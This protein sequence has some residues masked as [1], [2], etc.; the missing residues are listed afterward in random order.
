M[1]TLYTCSNNNGVA[2]YALDG[3][4]ITASWG[5]K[6]IKVFGALVY[7]DKEAIIHDFLATI[8]YQASTKGLFTGAYIA[9]VKSTYFSASSSDVTTTS[10]IGSPSQS[11]IQI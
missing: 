1:S 6:L 3:S 11:S 9:S 4:A 2:V 5:E 8:L 10:L 7:Q